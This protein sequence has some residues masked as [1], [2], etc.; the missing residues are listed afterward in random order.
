VKYLIDGR[1]MSS[2]PA[3]YDGEST[4]VSLTGIPQVLV[5]HVDLLPGGQSSLYG[6]DA[7]AGVVNVVLKKTLDAPLLDLRYGLYSQGGGSDK[8]IGL[9][10]GF[11][12]GSTRVLIGAQY[13]KTLPIWGYQRALTASRFA[14]GATPQRANFDYGVYQK[15]GPADY[16]LDPQNCAAVAGQFGNSVKRV[17]VPQEGSY[18][19]TTRDGFSTIDNGTSSLQLY[20]HGTNE[21]NEHAQVY[22]DTLL[23]HEVTEFSNG[24]GYWSTTVNYGAFYDPN[25]DDLVNLQHLFSPEESSGSQHLNKLDDTRFRAGVGVSG[26]W[27]SGW[28]YDVNLTRT[29]ET[30]VKH[31][32]VQFTDPIGQYFGSILGPSQ[33]VD[34]YFGF[35]PVFTPDYAAFYQPVSP[36]AF[37]SFSGYAHSHS[38]TTENILRAQ[39][40]DTRL[41]ELPG[42]DAAA[43]LV[44]EAGD[45]TWNYL[46]DVRLTDGSI[47]EY[48]AVTGSGHR[49]RQAASAELRLPVLSR[50]NFTLS[51][52]YD[53]YR[54]AGSNVSKATYMGGIEIRPVA[55]LSLHGRYGTA[56]KAP[57]LADE[58]QGISGGYSLATDY[59]QCSLQGY[60]EATLGNCPQYGQFIFSPT[61]GSLKLKP[62]TAQVWQAGLTWTDAER[63]SFS[64]DYLHWNI[65][66]E[67]AS[68]DADQLLK[69]EA[70]CR[71]GT[72]DASSPTC[73]AALLQVSRDVTGEV[74]SI[75]TP[76]VNVS[77]ERVGA[78]VANV[79]YGVDWQKWGRLAVELAWS[80][81]LTHTYQQ[82]PG[83]PVIDYLR[84]PTSS[85]DFKSKVTGSVSW[86]QRAWALT[87][88]VARYGRTPNY[89]ATLVGSENPGAGRL[90]PWTVCNFSVQYGGFRDL[91]LS[92]NVDNAFNAMPPVDH[93]YPG[94]TSV[95]YNDANYSVYGRSWFATL[96]Y[97]PHW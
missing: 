1:P 64:A 58:Y 65:N 28:S 72:Y 21:L 9:A 15:F 66:N 38:A 14:A 76:K 74:N 49:T 19:G 70:L 88:Y 51:N 83:D 62:I 93:T 13:E 90:A 89:Q 79:R 6:S 27:T 11:E 41:F 18:C 46:P 36:Q 39:V 32:Y 5:D 4:I 95:P 69:T 37:A 20:L 29:Q 53:N 8:R 45:E 73:Q 52:R 94:S 84:D 75:F 44:A 77:R 34:P 81:E 26:S 91:T 48:T 12:W 63:V 67:V 35:F 40:T 54:V 57:S 30:L 47:Y 86:R 60:T 7:I 78:V 80:D 59:Y 42:G 23:S 71:L 87:S 97:S 25:L 31:T 22:M 56:F 96:T 24:N 85:T 16:F 55:S 17:T 68:Q 3:L 33:G 61:S 43:A 92:L 82:Y 50:V 2:Y 10:D